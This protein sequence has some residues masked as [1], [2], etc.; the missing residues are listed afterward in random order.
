MNE[1]K[2]AQQNKIMSQTKLNPHYTFNNY[3][4]GDFNELSY[5]VAKVV[6]NESVVKYNPFFIYGREG[7]IHLIQAIGNEIEKL[8]KNKRV[9]YI[10]SE[11]LME[12][13]QI[14]E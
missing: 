4:I 2:P 3:I 8:Y 13:L 14:S 10:T 6:V 1:K 12:V 7:K 11:V 5:V 9:V